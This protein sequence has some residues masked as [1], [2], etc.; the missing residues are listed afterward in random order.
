MTGTVKESVLL[1]CSAGGI[2]VVMAGKCEK[3]FSRI[4]RV[5]GLGPGMRGEKDEGREATPEQGIKGY[6]LFSSTRV[7]S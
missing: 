7:Y 3:D 6:S 1:L 5:H 2:V 4:H